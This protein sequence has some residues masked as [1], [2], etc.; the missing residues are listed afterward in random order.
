MTRH[1]HTLDGLRGLAALAV[2][3]MHAGPWLR[4]IA[5]PHAYLAVDL[6]FALSGLV[7]AHA[8]GGRLDAGLGAGAFLRMRLV[9]LYPL[10]ILGTAIGLLF[11]IATTR[12]GARLGL[13][14]GQVAVAM[15]A[16]LAMLPSPVAMDAKHWLA[17]FNV[18][19]WS[20]IF[21]LGANLLLA[22]IWR[23]LSGAVLAA[24]IVSSGLLF[25]A[26][27]L[28]HGSADV[29]GDAATALLGVPRTLFSFFVG[30][31]LHRLSR[32][33]VRVSGWAWLIPAVIVPVAMAAPMPGGAFDL[34]CIVLL[35]PL[36]IHLGALI[37]PP[38][39][40]GYL[41]LGAISYAIY[42]LHSPLLPVFTNLAKLA[43]TTVSALAPWGGVAV[44]AGLVVIAWVADMRYDRPVR[45]R[46]GRWL[47]PR[48]SARS[49][50]C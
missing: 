17:P 8:Y 2:V 32:P 9:R 40:R 37:E 39:A 49:A 43:G 19:A 12:F 24:I 13:P 36:L 30:I 16:A 50:A 35:F 44:V 46:L 21:E 28:V 20:L 6:F 14:P 18:A 3:A 48:Q 33:G 22:L 29:G 45:R 47:L 4:P 25:A 7:I 31:A 11:F 5:F 1:Y 42:A 34:A 15:A 10:Y 26:Q 27:T 23:R 38:S 41:H